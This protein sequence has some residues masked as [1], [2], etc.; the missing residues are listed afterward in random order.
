MV[1]S[2]EQPAKGVVLVGVRD[3]DDLP[4]VRFAATLAGR[5]KASLRLLSAWTLLRYL[6]SAAPVVQAVREVA[7][8]AAAASTRILGEVREEFP[9]LTV[10]DDVVQVPSPAGA[11]VEASGHADLLVVG[12]RKHPHAP[13]TSLGRVA[14]AMLHHAHCPVAVFPR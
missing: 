8:A 7:E 1:Q 13:G 12:A 14:H 10:G 6:E 3:E 5:R 4:A 2:S 9:D 11:L